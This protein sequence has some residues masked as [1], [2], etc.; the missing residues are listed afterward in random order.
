MPSLDERFPALTTWTQDHGW[1]EVGLIEGFEARIQVLDEGG[2]IWSGASSYPTLDAA[3]QE[4][5][6]A[7]AQWLEEQFGG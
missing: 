1:I 6:Q 7:V 2:L 5:E 3:F 4:A